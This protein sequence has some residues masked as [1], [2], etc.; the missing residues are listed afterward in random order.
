MTRRPVDTFS[1]INWLGFIPNDTSAFF[2]H[3]I[4]MLDLPPSTSPLTG[5]PVPADFIHAST[6]HFQDN[7]G[8]TLLLRGVNLSGSTKCPK[9]H[10]Q[11]LGDDLW[12][13]AEGGADLSWVGMPLNLEDGSADVSVPWH[14]LFDR[15]RRFRWAQLALTMYIPYRFI[16]VDCARGVGTLCVSCSHGSPS[17]MRDL[18]NTITNTSI[19]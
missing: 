13:S 6:L 10:P 5:K 9:G 8:R 17:N 12:D 19:T 2:K 7:A 11:Q 18:S 3:Q 4:N 16:W 14:T 1:S 15:P